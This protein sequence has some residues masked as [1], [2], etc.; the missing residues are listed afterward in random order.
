MKVG[1]FRATEFAGL[2]HDMGTQCRKTSAFAGDFFNITV[3]KDYTI[4]YLNMP[5]PGYKLDWVGFSNP[6]I[7]IPR[8]K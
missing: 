4:L 1:Y 6:V 7:R 5:N 3:V 8:Q 2:C